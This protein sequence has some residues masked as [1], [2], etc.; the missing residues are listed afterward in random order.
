MEIRQEVSSIFGQIV[1]ESTDLITNRREIRTVVQVDAG[2][3][4]VLGGLIQ[5]EVQRND[6]GIPGL[7][8]VPFAGRLFRSE[9]TSRRRTNLMVFLRPTIVNTPAQ[10]QAVTQRQYDS[11]RAAPIDPGLLRQLEAEILRETPPQQSPQPE[12]P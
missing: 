10:A 12:A 7:R 2:Q 6:S 4:I 3:I 11:V 1:T 8:R 5:D 9:G